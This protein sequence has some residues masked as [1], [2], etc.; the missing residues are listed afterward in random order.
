MASLR[1]ELSGKPDTVERAMSKASAATTAEASSE[2]VTLSDARGETATGGIQR[3]PEAPA[4]QRR[5]PMI[6][7]VAGCL[8]WIGSAGAFLWGYFGPEQLLALGP[9]LIAF[10]AAVT[11]IPPFLFIAAA[12]V[13]LRAQEL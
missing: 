1:A 8:F 5:M 6:F 10:A 2:P 4:R 9:H 11:F 7:A 3:S 13:L 12:Y